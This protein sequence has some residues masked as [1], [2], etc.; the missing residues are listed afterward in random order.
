MFHSVW[1]IAETKIQTNKKGNLKSEICSTSLRQSNKI[2]HFLQVV[3]SLR[4]S[5]GVRSNSVG[6]SEGGA[7]GGRATW[8]S[9]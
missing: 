7:R 8:A 3:L 4:R 2:S 9:L 6:G 1:N 5:S